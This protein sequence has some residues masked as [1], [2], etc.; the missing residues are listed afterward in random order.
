M[1][2]AWNASFNELR[3]AGLDE[4]TV[5][6]IVLKRN[7]IN[8][9]KEMEKVQKEGLKI[10]TLQDENYPKLLKEI[11]APPALMYYRGQLSDEA[12][13]FSL[14]VVGTRKFTNYGKQI[15]PQIVRGLTEN[16]MVIVSGLALGIDSLAHE[17]CLD[18]GGR[19]IAVLGSGLDKQSIYPSYNRY[20]ADKIL[21]QNGLV[22]SEYPIGM[23]PLRHNFPQR[24]RI[25][26][27][28][29]LGILVIEAPESSGALLTAR[30]ALEQNREVF[31]VP[32][33]IYD[34][35]AIGPN[36]LIKMGAKLVICAEDILEAL[37]LNLVKDFVA[38]KKIV[39][40]SKE[41][42][43]ILKHLSNEAIH[44]D[45]LARLTKFDTSV[46]N[47]T[48]TLMEMKG[49]VRNLGSLMYVVSC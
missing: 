38:T 22:L 6:E 9:D 49:R 4:K 5:D 26:S 1:Q 7:E 33:T 19:T 30:Y 29:S 41:E 23:Q 47:S 27:G 48:L 15:T 2:Q 31:A 3:Q 18:A 10:L 12:D 8:L 35:N 25:V 16:G 24:N 20:L 40:D 42:A 44:I 21:A 36:N 28:L 37:D 45:Q 46:I 13:D 34:K 39:P 11:Y 17:A 14:G 32:G 43:E